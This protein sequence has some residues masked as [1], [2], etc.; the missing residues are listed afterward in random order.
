VG[1]NAAIFSQNGGNIGIGFTIP[2]NLVKELMPQ[3]KEDGKVTRGWLGV[4]IQNVTP[5]IAESLGLKKA[6]GA[7]VANVSKHGPAER[8]GIKVGDVITEFDGKKIKESKDLPIIVARTPVGKKVSVKVLRESKEVVLPLTIDELMEKEVIASVKGKGRLGL[9]VQ[10]VTPQ[11]AESLGLDSTD[12]VVITSV[13]QGSPGDEAGLR[14][15]D[16]IVEVDR[17]PIRDVKGLKDAT[18]KI[19]DGKSVLF[20]VQRGETTLFLAMKSR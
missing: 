9:T 4:A 10:R 5:P 6:T 7:L 2:I 3:L 13:E 11:I 18:A 12:G 17:K 20:L 1:I 15:G 14:R 16:V 19:R 8:G